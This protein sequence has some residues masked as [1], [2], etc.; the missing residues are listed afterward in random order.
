MR[1]AVMFGTLLAPAMVVAA[2]SGR[3]DGDAAPVDG[4]AVDARPSPTVSAPPPVDASPEPSDA[5]IAPSPCDAPHLFCSDFSQGQLG[6]G[7]DATSDPAS[8]LA[9]EPSPACGGSRCLVGRIDGD[10]TH[11][12]SLVKSFVPPQSGSFKVRL[13]VATE[14]LVLGAGGLAVV[15][16]QIPHPQGSRYRHVNLFAS[17]AGVAIQAAS[18]YADGGGGGQSRTLGPLTSGSHRFEI[19]VT[20]RAGSVEATATMDGAGAQTVAL[21]GPIAQKIN[22]VVGLP[23]RP[24]TTAG[25][26]YVDDVVVDAL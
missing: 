26:A 7:W 14:G 9:V 20:A 11:E 18:A 4:G 21:D 5:A 17:S 24:S 10:P 16:V 13:D 6:D 19:V 2:C 25:T 3:Y 1:Y 8:L 12:S 22:L 15:F 23:Y